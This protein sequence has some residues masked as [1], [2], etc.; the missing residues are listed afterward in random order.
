MQ[1][2]V[3]QKDLILALNLSLRTIPSNT[4]LPVLQYVKLYIKRDTITFYATNLSMGVKYVI[5][6]SSSGEGSLLLHCRTFL[7][8]MRRFPDDD[9]TFSMTDYSKISVECQTIKVT[10]KGFD[11]VEFPELSFGN[12]EEKGL[13]MDKRVLDKAISHVM[14]SIKKQDDTNPLL[15]GAFL[16]VKNKELTMVGLDGYRLSLLKRELDC[17]PSL[18][19]S[20]I[21]PRRVL[22]EILNII[23]SVEEETL[24]IAFDK[25]KVYFYCK[26]ISLYSTLIEGQY[27]NYNAIIPKK[28]M[29]ET[30][31]TV[32]RALLNNTVEL[33]S[34]ISS[35]NKNKMIKITVEGN[36]LIVTSNSDIGDFHREL[37]VDTKG[38]EMEIAFNSLYVLD[39]LKSF[40]SEY[41]TLSFI[42][43]LKPCVVRPYEEE[44]LHML[45]PVRIK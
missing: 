40:D 12:F 20:E 33:A 15:T 25:N 44:D 31:V 29:T 43:S 38:K 34:L 3:K 17:D 13:T 4:T 30:M 24:S 41:V 18:V 35:Q 7:D 36:R 1:F 23:R 27:I 21:L 9:I 32:E 2:T 39:A 8:I 16:E 45:L 11:P 6:A 19:L 37:T 28:E 22:E 5:P 14:V 26:D 42:D 10:M